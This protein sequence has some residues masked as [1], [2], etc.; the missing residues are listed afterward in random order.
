MPKIKVLYIAIDSSMGGSTASLLNLI[1]S[2]RDE[3]YPIV[4]FPEEGVGQSCFMER[5]IVKIK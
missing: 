2:V 3:V 4:L 5:V 1:E